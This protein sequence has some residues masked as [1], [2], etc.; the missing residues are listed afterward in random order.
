MARV[1]D[2]LDVLDR[3]H[4]P[5]PGDPGLA[6]YKEWYHF[7]LLDDA[8]GIDTIVNISLAGDPFQPD[9][10][11]AN[12][13]L[14]AFRR[15]GGWTGGIDQYD[16]LAATV[17]E[18]TTD[19]R[20]GRSRLIWRE[21]AFLL[22]AALRDGSL[23]IRCRLSPMTDP[24]IIWKNTPIGSGHLNW[25]ILP[26]LEA[27]GCLTIGQTTHRFENVR[28]YHDHNWGHWRWGENLGWDWGFSSRVGRTP[29]GEFLTLV[30][31]RTTDRQGSTVQEHTLAVWKGGTLFKLFTRRCLD[32]SRRGRFQPDRIARIPGAMNLNNPGQVLTVPGQVHV[33]AKDA[34]DWLD[35]RYRVDAARQ[36]S[37]PTDLGFGTV[38]LNETFGRISITG[39][40]AGT[41]VACEG[42]ACFE[43][44]A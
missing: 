24:M 17:D 27:D 15:D 4:L 5:T 26:W 19:I 12:I 28:A 40:L 2:H 37:I 43:F 3:P 9:G 18:Q 38:E 21:G 8:A 16:A 1:L 20:L 36:V 32:Y 6:S 11:D 25:L 42:Q 29:D 31:D 13:I 35:V 23:A 34:N 39:Y 7:N 41:P 44:V 30:Y 33:V 14:L 22:D 10:G